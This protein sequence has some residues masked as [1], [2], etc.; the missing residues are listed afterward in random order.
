MDS[1]PVFSESK[2]LALISKAMQLAI[3]THPWVLAFLNAGGVIFGG[4]LMHALHAAMSNEG[5]IAEYLFKE[6]GDIDFMFVGSPTDIEFTIKHIIGNTPMI[7]TDRREYGDNGRMRAHYIVNSNIGDG[8]IVKFDISVTGDKLT[9]S[10]L[11]PRYS[12]ENIIMGYLDGPLALTPEEYDV[13]RR[14]ERHAV[15]MA[16]LDRITAEKE[17]A[18]EV[19]KAI[20]KEKEEATWTTVGKSKELIKISESPK[21]RSPNKEPL[22]KLT[23]DL[24]FTHDNCMTLA[25]AISHIQKKLLII[26]EAN[27]SEE[28]SGNPP[29]FVNRTLRRLVVPVGFSNTKTPFE[30][31][32]NPSKGWTVSTD[33]I[34]TKVIYTKMDNIR[35]ESYFKDPRF[36]WLGKS[37]MGKTFYKK[38]WDRNYVLTNLTKVIDEWAIFHDFDEWRA[39]TKTISPDYAKLLLQYHPELLIEIADFEFKADKLTDGMLTALQYLAMADREDEFMRVLN[40]TTIEIIQN[41]SRTGYRSFIRNAIIEGAPVKYLRIMLE[42]GL[43]LS[44]NTMEEI[45]RNANPV[46]LEFCKNLVYYDVEGGPD[47]NTSYIYIPY[48]VNKAFIMNIFKHSRINLEQ[49]EWIVS[50]YTGAD[51]ITQYELVKMIERTTDEVT[52]PGVLTRI[53]NLLRSRTPIGGYNTDVWSLTTKIVKSFRLPEHENLTL[54]TQ[55][56]DYLVE[57]MSDDDAL[58]KIQNIVFYTGRGKPWTFELYFCREAPIRENG[59]DKFNRYLKMF[60]YLIERFP[61]FCNR[62]KLNEERIIKAGK[63]EITRPALTDDQITLLYKN[64]DENVDTSADES[65]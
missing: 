8:R 5:H 9:T 52:K 10:C 6:D 42:K 24:M 43:K 53:L 14:A 36:Y 64:I 17:A 60:Q 48:Y 50:N 29:K 16:E 39:R 23:M 59:K 54:I 65:E 44:S 25:D 26:V 47:W 32:T 57:N 31:S 1:S 40:R 49:V 58:K 20:A 11:N 13:Y 62:D 61:N 27:A 4:F 51:T 18:R 46:I 35:D 12:V 38:G 37:L 15:E 33:Y 30:T 45:I 63:R 19:Q 22:R 2:N 28:Y 56:I 3:H 34:T 55:Y 41:F 7:T 21:K